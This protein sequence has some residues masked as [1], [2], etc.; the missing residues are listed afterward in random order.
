MNAP[1]LKEG[2][3]TVTRG[4]AKLSGGGD[5]AGRTSLCVHGQRA[6]PGGGGGKSTSLLHSI[7]EIVRIIGPCGNRA[8]DRRNLGRASGYR[9]A[10]IDPAILRRAPHRYAGTRK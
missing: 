5:G 2:V 9:S 8:K 3:T 10:Y 7:G 6:F 1:G 4:H